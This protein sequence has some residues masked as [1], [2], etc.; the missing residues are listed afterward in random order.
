[1]HAEI[2]YGGFKF[3]CLLLEKKAYLID[4]FKFHEMKFSTVLMNWLIREKMFTFFYNKF[5][6]VNRM[7]YMKCG[8]NASLLTQFWLLQKVCST[9]DHCFIMTHSICREG[10]ML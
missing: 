5:K 7:H 10:D 9:L 3:Y 6:P 2:Y 1:M 8:V 4:S